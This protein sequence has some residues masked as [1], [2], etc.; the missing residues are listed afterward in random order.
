VEAV[1]PLVSTLEGVQQW[2]LPGA[3]EFDLRP[4]GTFR[5]HWQNVIREFR[6]HEFIGFDGMRW[7]LRPRD[8]GS[9][10]ALI[11]TWGA[12]AA[13]TEPGLG[14]EQPGG[15]GT[16]WAGVAAGWH[17]TVDALEAAVTGQP[18]EERFEE[19]CRYYAAYLR[20]Y[21]RWLEVTSNELA[22]AGA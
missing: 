10:F 3:S 7:E 11:D 15:P 21:Y 6:E 4:G 1:W 16:P 2:W 14:S 12:E 22:P 17:G 13:P 9:E 5:H 8:G 18:C 20:D 19:R